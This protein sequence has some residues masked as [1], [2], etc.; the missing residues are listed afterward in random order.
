MTKP[1]NRHATRAQELGTCAH[2]HLTGMKLR[3]KSPSD[4]TAGWPC[5]RDL[6]DFRVWYVS[7]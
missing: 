1:W 7:R 2:T 3:L 6:G 5:C 4:W